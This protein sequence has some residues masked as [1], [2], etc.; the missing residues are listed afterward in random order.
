MHELQRGMAKISVDTE[1]VNFYFFWDGGRQPGT[2]ADISKVLK[3]NELH[4]FLVL[5]QRSLLQWLLKKLSPFG[6]IFSS[7]KKAGF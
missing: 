4:G 3:I 5:S 1:R 7:R 2:E 6:M